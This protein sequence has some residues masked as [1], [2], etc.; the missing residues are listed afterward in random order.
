MRLDLPTLGMPTTIATAPVVANSP[1]L[2]P[3]SLTQ[4]SS[5][6]TLVPVRPQ[7]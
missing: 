1:R 3:R 2:A 4:A 7:A 5:L 6:C